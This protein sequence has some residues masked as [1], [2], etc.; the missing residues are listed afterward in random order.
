MAVKVTVH[1]GTHQVGGVATEVR[2]GMARIVID[3]GDELSVE[4]GFVPADLDIDGV[5]NASG[6]C[7]AVLLTHYH[8][9]HTGQMARVRED[10]PLYMGALAKEV[11]LMSARRNPATDPALLQ[12][13]EVVRTFRAGEPLS[14]GD[15]R[16]TPYCIDHSAVDAYMFLVEAGGRRLLHTGDFRLHGIRRSA[17]PKVLSKLVRKVDCVVTE[18]TTASRPAGPAV[19][20]RDLR[21]RLKALLGEHKY[22]L[23]LCAATNLDRVFSLSRAVPRGRYC[24]AD[25][26]QCELVDKVCEN[27]AGLSPFYERPKLNWISTKTFAGFKE[28]GGLMFVRD[29][30]SF[31]RLVSELDTA[32]SVMLYCMWD[33]Y[34]TRPGSTIPSLLEMAGSW[35]PLHTSGH[36]S[37]EDIAAVVEMVDPEVVVPM[38]TDAPQALA[39]ALAGRNVSVLQDGEELE[40]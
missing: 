3:M 17:M 33:G 34:R 11:M 13:M 28:R 20:E 22:V 12:R 15:T 4:P 36:A 6:R 37:V 26:Y 9:D 5:T 8:G 23:A 30:R 19:T 2:T 27:W 21:E 32:Q 25:R 7:D 14:F 18:G 16:V 38:H 1:R 10:I 39:A 35:E 24:L 31:R 40:I 29:N